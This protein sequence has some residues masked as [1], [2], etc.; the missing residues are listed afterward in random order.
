MRKFTSF[1][2]VA[3]AL[4]LGQMAIHG[5]TTGS[6]SGTVMDQN[7]A[8]VPGASVKI[9][10]EAGQQFSTVTNDSG[11]YRVP[12]VQNGNY[13]VTVSM[14]GFK[15]STVTNVKVDVGTPVTVDAKLEIGNVGEIV[16]ISSGGEVLQTETAA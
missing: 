12:A 6:I 8:L 4:M 5:Q 14:T 10:G 9:K 3:A 2:I 13:T 11:A 7:G 16:E 15:T 1:L